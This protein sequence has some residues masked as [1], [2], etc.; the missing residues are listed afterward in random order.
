MSSGFFERMKILLLQPPIQDFYNTDIRLQPV[1]LASLKAAVKK[2]FPEIEVV[3]KDYHHGWGRRTIQ[4]PKELIN[5]KPF[6]LYPDK[7]P[8][9]L[10]NRYYHFGASF[11][12]IAQEVIQ[13]SPDIVGISSHLFCHYI[14]W[15]SLSM[16]FLFCSSDIWESIP[17]KKRQFSCG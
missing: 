15:L 17:S 3:V 1:G 8:F 10:F 2:H 6:Y 12:T 16:Y 7:S 11:E 14:T 9:A 4:L 5:L 13:Y